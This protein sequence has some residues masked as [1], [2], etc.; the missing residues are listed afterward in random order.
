MT[1]ILLQTC[2]LLLILTGAAG[3]RRNAIELVES[4]LLTDFNSLAEKAYQEPTSATIGLLA[5]SRR[6][7][8]RAHAWQ[9]ISA[10][11]LISA[12]AVGIAALVSLFA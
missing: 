9:A 1:I 8:L 2:G 7:S 3:S 10:L 11:L 4:A 5:E 6:L 12:F